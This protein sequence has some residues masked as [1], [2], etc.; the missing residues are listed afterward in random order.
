VCGSL[1]RGVR[2]FGFRCAGLCLGV[3][4]CL[5][6]GVRV[7]AFGCAGVWVQVCAGAWSPLVDERH[8]RKEDVN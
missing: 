8:L 2:V 4:G 3:C 6:S 7:F 5:V 1:P